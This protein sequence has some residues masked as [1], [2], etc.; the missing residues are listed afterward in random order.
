MDGKLIKIFV[1]L[2]RSYLRKPPIT[3]AAILQISMSLSEIP[4]FVFSVNQ[5][6]AT[7][8]PLTIRQSK[9]YKHGP[10]DHSSRTAALIPLGLTNCTT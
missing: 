4:N 7:R 5:T 6:V 3:V 1:V 8:K 2:F 10:I 9:P